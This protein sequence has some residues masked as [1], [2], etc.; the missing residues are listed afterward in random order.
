MS[1]ST[2]ETPYLALVVLKVA[3]LTGLRIAWRNPPPALVIP[4]VPGVTS[5]GAFV[6]EIVR[7][8]ASASKAPDHIINMPRG[9]GD[10]GLPLETVV[11]STAK[12]VQI[13]WTISAPPPSG[14]LYLSTVPSPSYP[15]AFICIPAFAWRF[16]RGEYLLFITTSP[17]VTRPVDESKTSLAW[18]K[19]WRVFRPLPT[20]YAKS[21]NSRSFLWF[22]KIHSIHHVTILISKF[23]RIWWKR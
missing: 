4:V 20:L 23:G 14:M 10:N 2:E 16:A 21:W 1:V 9:L 22:L 8:A 3:E 17:G 15:F 5:K 7:Q 18:A 11:A 13:V 6:R 19:F 12:D